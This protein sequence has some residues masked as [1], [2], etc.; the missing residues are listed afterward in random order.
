MNYCLFK[1]GVKDRRASLTDSVCLILVEDSEA[2]ILYELFVVP[3]S[4]SEH[5]IWKDSYIIL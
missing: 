1:G 5:L 4:L 2:L 3:R